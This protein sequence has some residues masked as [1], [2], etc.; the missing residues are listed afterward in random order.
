MI[1]KSNNWKISPFD[2]ERNSR[3]LPAMRIFKTADIKEKNS[4]IVSSGKWCLCVNKTAFLSYVHVRKLRISERY[5][6]FPR[7][8]MIWGKL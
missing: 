5:T 7:K 2:L 3:F 8:A 4:K 1:Y 6:S